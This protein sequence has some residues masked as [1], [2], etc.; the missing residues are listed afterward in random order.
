MG[1]FGLVFRHL[2][3]RHGAS[4]FPDLLRPFPGGF[5]PPV[6]AAAGLIM[7]AKVYRNIS[8]R[9]EWF[10]LEPVDAL[11]LTLLFWALLLVHEGAVLWNLAVLVLS[12]VALRLVKHG[13]PPGYTTAR[14]L[15]TFRPRAFLSA[16]TPD[17]AGRAH[18]FSPRPP[19]AA[20]SKSKTHR[21]GNAP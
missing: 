10:G 14:A 20:G 17:R 7:A 11:A 5:V 21:K 9:P 15:Y 16:A 19:H 13:K 4:R 1:C 18:P 3:C 6:F 12:Y 2:A 8:R